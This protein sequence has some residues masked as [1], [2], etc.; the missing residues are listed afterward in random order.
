MSSTAADRPLRVALVWNESVLAEE[1]YDEPTAVKLGRDGLFEL[2][3]GVT[4]AEE[5]E[6]FSASG[7]AFAFKPDPAIGGD[8]WLGGKRTPV[9]SLSG[10][11]PIGPEDYGVLTVG[12]VAVFFQHVKGAKAPPKAMARLDWSLIACVMLSL[13][14]CGSFLAI[15]FLD[16]VWNGRGEIDPFELDEELVSRFLVTPPPEDLLED[17]ESGTETEDPGLRAR[18]ETGGERHE[19]DEGRVGHENAAREDTEIEGE[20]SDQ[21]ATKVR[22][23]GLLGALAGDPESNPIAAALDIPNISD[24]LGGTGALA[25]NVGRGSRGAGLRGTGMG[26]GGTG[27]GSLFGAGNVGTGI[28]SGMG[29]TGMGS[30]GIGARGRKNT[31]VAI[32]VT[33]GAPR[34]SGYL[35]AEQIN[36]VVRANQAAVRYCY[37]VEVQRQPNLRGRVSIAWRINLQGAVTTSRVANSTLNNAR[38]EGCIVRQVR[39]WRFPQPDGGEV[40]VEYPFIFGVQ[41][42]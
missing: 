38:V 12:P 15:G 40:S 29:G 39:R 14:L 26:G 28:G 7:N 5:L 22:S 21:V 17:P 1:L 34:V 3:E 9:S 36:R 24:L 18:E 37:E 27:P 30:D 42:G 19:G 8:V 23:M 25:T 35:S 6:V 16:W 2:P 20:V 11:T 4:G 33:R 13:F 10:P 32:S 31:E 41:G